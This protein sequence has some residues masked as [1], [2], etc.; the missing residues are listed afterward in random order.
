M[1]KNVMKLLSLEGEVYL[2]DRLISPR[3]V[4]D[5]LVKLDESS[6][7]DTSKAVSRERRKT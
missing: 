4:K 5:A 2:R 1:I 3:L 7:I 6:S